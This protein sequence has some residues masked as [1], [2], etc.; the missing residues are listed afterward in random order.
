MIN[1]N[2][3]FMSENR[4]L[5]VSFFFFHWHCILKII[6]K[7]RRR[8][9]FF[10]QTPHF[11]C[12][13][14]HLFLSW[15]KDIKRPPILFAFIFASHSR[16]KGITRRWKK[17]LHSRNMCERERCAPAMLRQAF[18]THTPQQKILLI[19]RISNAQ[20]SRTRS[21]DIRTIFCFHNM[22]SRM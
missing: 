21:L 15:I 2:A 10:I 12:K 8:Y 7:T 4:S 14:F 22:T 5:P 3:F 17:W 9:I 18:F 13:Y 19:A 6:H 16:K 1:K 20:W 11:S